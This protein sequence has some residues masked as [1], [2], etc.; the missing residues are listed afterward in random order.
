MKKGQ[1]SIE[2]MIIYGLAILIA[3]SVI[4]GLFYFDVFNVATYLPSS[5][6]LGGTGDVRCEEMRF[7][8]SDSE[9]A[10]GIRNT[11]QRPLQMLKINVSDNEN[12]HF[13]G[14]KGATAELASGPNAGNTVSNTYPL[15]PGDIAQV[16]IDTGSAQEDQVLRGTLVARYQY[17]DGAI[18]QESVGSIRVRPS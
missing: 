17:Q 10:L 12:V 15:A 11:G 8:S 2:T 6:D 14:N 18:E 16:I 5:C 7:S 9:L 13:N 4:G 1:L 3:L